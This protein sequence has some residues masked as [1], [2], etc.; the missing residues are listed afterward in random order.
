MPLIGYACISTGEPTL[1]P[2]LV[3]LCEA[4]C[5]LIHEEQ[6][7]VPIARALSCS[8]FLQRSGLATRW[9][10]CAWSGWRVPSAISC[11]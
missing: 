6:A 8:G 3:E 7:P 9:W 11:R 2:Q 4:G 1:D 10:W 5:T